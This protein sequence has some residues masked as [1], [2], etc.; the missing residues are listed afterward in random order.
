MANR[1]GSQQHR[2]IP[3]VNM[4]VVAILANACCWVPPLLL[5]LGGTAARYAHFI[6]PYRPYLL[7]LMALQLVWGFRNAYKSHSKCC[8]AEFER[9]R[10]IR[11]ITFWCIAAVVIGLN[12]IP[13]THS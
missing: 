1:L 11:I 13:H 10:R 3:I 2:V 8:G 7:A 4:I 6:E 9:H 5:A 12:L